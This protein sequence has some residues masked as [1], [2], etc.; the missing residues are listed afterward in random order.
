MVQRPFTYLG[1]VTGIIGKVAYTKLK[2]SFINAKQS[3]NC[4]GMRK[5]YTSLLM[6]GL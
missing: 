4:S 5:R 1:S 6:V 2:Y 3:L